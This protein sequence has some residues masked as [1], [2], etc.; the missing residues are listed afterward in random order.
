[1]FNSL[2]PHGPYSPWSSPGQNTGVGS[3]SLLQG[4]FPA[5]GLNSGL[6]HCRWILYQLN[7]KGIPRILE[8]VACLFSSRSSRPR[9][10]TG[11][12]QADSL[13][14]ELSGKPLNDILNG[15][16]MKSKR[17]LKI[18]WDSDNENTSIQN[19]RVQ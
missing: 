10:Q 13:P 17:K 15:S 5:Q 7:H 12:L 19:L 3:I 1:M 6:P 18:S 2:W 14:T 11:V 9:N 16:T 4:I 8:W